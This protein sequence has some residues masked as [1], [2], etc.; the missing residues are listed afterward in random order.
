MEYMDCGE[1][2]KDT[3]IE[4]RSITPSVT[5]DCLFI[6]CLSDIYEIEQRPYPY[7]RDPDSVPKHPKLEDDS[8]PFYLLNPLYEED[9]ST[10]DTMKHP[11]IQYS[12]FPTYPNKAD[13]RLC[14]LFDVNKLNISP[15]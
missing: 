1:C 14:A 2:Y 7:S 15:D 9:G 10:R 5:R 12:R 4:L 11:I 13:I 3:F 8:R 6:P